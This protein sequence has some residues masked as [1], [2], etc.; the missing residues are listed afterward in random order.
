MPDVYD[1][2]PDDYE[3]DYYFDVTDPATLGQLNFWSLALLV[4]FI[5]LVIFWDRLVDVLRGP[6]VVGQE[7]PAIILWV[8]VLGVLLLHEWVHGVAIRWAGHRPRYG[9]QGIKIGPITI[10]YLLYAT[11]DD[12]YFPRTAFIV[13]ALAP[14]III[15]I[16][17]LAL[18]VILPDYLHSY[19]MVAIVINGT[20]A[21]GDLWMTAI[22][23]RYP[24]S[25]LVRDEAESISI[26]VASS[27]DGQPHPED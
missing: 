1:A 9:M 13:I 11:A 23:R 2:L 14:V 22:V 24:E 21:V 3:L 18:M 4:P 5:A 7:I 10:P 20:G 6:Y 16:V 27:S 19:L 8:L 25:T 26:F 12:A 15:T 17:G